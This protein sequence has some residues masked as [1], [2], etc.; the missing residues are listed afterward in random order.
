MK[1]LLPVLLLASAACVAPVGNGPVR[2]AGGPVLTH[3]TVIF[4]YWGGYWGTHL[5]ETDG[6]STRWQTLLNS[7]GHVLDRLQEYGVTGGTADPRIAMP[8]YE[9]V[10]GLDEVSVQFEL[11]G[12]IAAGLLPA[13]VT[14]T[15][16][17]IMLPPSVTTWFATQMHFNGYHTFGLY[18]G[19]PYTYAVIN[20]Q[21]DTTYSD[22]VVSHEIYEAATDPFFTTWGAFSQ[23]VGDMCEGKY[24]TIDGDVVQQVWSVA[25]SSCL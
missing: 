18:H 11:E 8:A 17:I 3:P 19:A 15:L 21:A 2:N 25:W 5:A 6:I 4:S 12:E 16:Y 14:G 24:V 13:P 10:N 1:N 9:P 22:V 23:E 7:P 20:Y